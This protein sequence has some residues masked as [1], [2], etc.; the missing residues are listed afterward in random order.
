MTNSNDPKGLGSKAGGIRRGTPPVV[1]AA[2]AAPTTPDDPTAVL[3]STPAPAPAAP[4]GSTPSA[5][6][7]HSRRRTVRRGHA[8]APAP[9]VPAPAPA[10]DDAPEPSEDTE[11]VTETPEEMEERIRKELK[12]EKEEKKLKNRVKRAPKAFGSW[13]LAWFKKHWFLTAILV[14]AL[15][16]S[17][18]MWVNGKFSD[19]DTAGE[20]QPKYS[21]PKA[22]MP[23]GDEG[24]Q[25]GSRAENAPPTVKDDGDALTFGY[26]DPN[27]S[28][29]TFEVVTSNDLT[30][31]EIKLGEK[32]KEYGGKLAIG[33]VDG[34]QESDVRCSSN[35]QNCDFS[36]E[37]ISICD[38]WLSLSRIIP[39]QGG[40]DQQQ[41]FWTSI[42]VFNAQPTGN[43]PGE[44]T[45]LPHHCGV[46][47]TNTSS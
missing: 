41:P 20:S 32:L 47:D 29:V 16:A 27:F 36:D 1:P 12:E 42:E 13:L 8:P 10:D 4:S 39:V 45:D 19:D 24:S 3:P 15:I 5:H 14:V 7:R 2:S 11:K 34:S 26:T 44:G 28:G 37:N 23:G 25:R 6:A 31:R 18:T 40:T 9:A 43:Y 33:T 22:I 35:A 17:L 46:K 30:I 21:A 38:A